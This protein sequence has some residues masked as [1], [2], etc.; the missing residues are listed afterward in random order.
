MLHWYSQRNVHEVFIFI[1]IR[2]KGATLMIIIA[3]S[4]GNR[5]LQDTTQQRPLTPKGEGRTPKT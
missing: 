3:R 5:S 2:W 4:P 1:T